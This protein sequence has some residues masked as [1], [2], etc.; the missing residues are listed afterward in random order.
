MLAFAG[1]FL[2]VIAANAALLEFAS[3]EFRRLNAEVQ[4]NLRRRLQ[5]QVR[6]QDLAAAEHR[7]PGVPGT[8]RHASRLATALA[9]LIE[10]SGLNVTPRKLALRAM[11]LAIVAWTACWLLSAN[12][13][14]ALLVAA[15][16][17]TAPCCTSSAPAI[18]AGKSCWGNCPTP[19][20]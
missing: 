2:A 13:V 20:S 11:L 7:G 1:A 5:T 3:G 15:A 18:N 16:A 8:P 9:Q 19:S 6:A 12:A 4:E 17:G 14:L 10:Q